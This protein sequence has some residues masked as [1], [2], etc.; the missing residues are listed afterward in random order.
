[1]ISTFITKCNVIYNKPE[2]G[3][4]IWANK[5]VPVMADRNTDRITYIEEVPT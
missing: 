5:L 4:G 3:G 2:G 1:M